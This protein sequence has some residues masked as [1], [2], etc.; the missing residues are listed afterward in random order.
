MEMQDV[1]V[2]FLPW[3]TF[4]NALFVATSSSIASC[5]ADPARALPQV[6]ITMVAMAS[7]KITFTEE[8]IM[9]IKY[10]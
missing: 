5:V 3:G 4:V 6:A 9:T 2:T 1:P 8:E 10:L 7:K